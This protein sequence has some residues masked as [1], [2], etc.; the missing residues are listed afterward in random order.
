MKNIRNFCIIAHIDHGKS[1]LADRFLEI[2]KTV[3]K[4]DMRKQLLDTMELE[5]ERGITIKLQPVRME[6]KGHN[7]NLIDTPGHVDFSFEIS[8]SLAACEGAILVVD[9]T[10]GIEAQT[11]ANLYLAIEQDLEI[12]PVVNKIDLPAAEPDRVKTE[13]ANV[14]GCNP[15]EIIEVSGK[16][17]TNVDKLLDQIIEKVPSPLDQGLRKKCNITNDDETRGLIFDSHFDQFRGVIAFV[18][19]VSGCIKKRDKAKL[20]SNNRDIEVLDCGF[21]KPDLQSFPEIKPGETGFVVTGLKDSRE[22]RAGDTLY[23]GNNPGKNKMLPGFRL[24]I[25]MVFAGFFPTD[26]DDFPTLRDALDKLAL[27]DSALVFEPETSTALGNGFRCGFLGL[28]HMEIIQERLDREFNLNIIATSPSVPIEVF[29]K[30]GDCEKITSPQLLPDPSEIDKL[31]EP[32]VAIEIMSPKEYVGAVMDLVTKRRG[33]FKNMQHPSEIRAIIS[34]EMP[35]A[36][37]ITDF[38]DVLK[39]VSSGYASMSFE[40]LD[41]REQDLVKMDILLAEKIAHAFSQIVHRT[42]AQNRGSKICKILK[43]N[44]PRKQFTIKIQ[45]AI[46]A[47]VIARE[48][49]SAYRKDVIEKLYGGDVTRKN[50]L[51]KK[52]K[53]GKKKMLEMGVGNVDVPKDVFLKVLKRED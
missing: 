26:A 40:V 18:R 16:E 33:I 44:L 19:V 25:P 8:R 42:E 46:G 13:I 34:A 23:I 38:H 47:R 15:D 48:T 7:L 10:Q 36:N 45:A 28:L 52:Q 2:T 30:H 14:I 29:K 37:V 53:K 32:W 21:F 20:L 41:F 50:K 51:L 43:N 22:V 49:I 3:A 6:W 4:R 39:S 24:P 31:K 12:I 27:E 5:Q 9:C 1:T 35:L 11:L 17:G